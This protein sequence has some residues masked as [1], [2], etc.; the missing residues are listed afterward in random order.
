MIRKQSRKKF[1]GNLNLF[2]EL[3][4]RNPT[5]IDSH[6]HVHQRES[7]IPI[8]SEIADR[9]NITLRGESQKVNYCG[10]FYGQSN[11][12]ST[13]RDAISVANLKKIISKLPEGITELACHPGLM[14]NLKTMYK[15]ERSIE[16]K[17][18][19]N[20]SV[21]EKITNLKIKL[22]SFKGIPF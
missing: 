1:I 13:F 6:Q 7:I 14:N 2:Y 18:L 16:V 12:G 21:K 9:L 5:H 22:C 4:G 20:K 19:C 17:T 15:I 10:S 8:V 11:D 3:M